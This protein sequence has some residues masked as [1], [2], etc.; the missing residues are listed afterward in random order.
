MEEILLY[1]SWI[2]CLLLN[3]GL[4]EGTSVWVTLNNESD[5]W[6]DGLYRTLCLPCVKLST[7]KVSR[8]GI[9]HMGTTPWAIKKGAT[10]IF[11]ITLANVDRF[12]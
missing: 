8:Y 12:Q 2:G 6:T 3:E 4:P 11:R 5:Y 1:T 9:R 10:F 7:P